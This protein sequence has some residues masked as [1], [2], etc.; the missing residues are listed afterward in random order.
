MSNLWLN[1][2]FGVWHLQCER[3]TLKFKLRR[4]EA[5]NGAKFKIKVYEIRRP[6]W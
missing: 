1:I 6:W 4:N 5:H 2:R 3:G